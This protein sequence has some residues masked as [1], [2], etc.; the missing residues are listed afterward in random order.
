MKSKKNKI[1][2]LSMAFAL[3]V[4]C[5]SGCGAGSNG[6]SNDYGSEDSSVNI[7]IDKGDPDNPGYIFEADG[8]LTASS[9]SKQDTINRLQATDDYG[10]SSDYID[11]YKKDKDRYVGIFYFTWLGWHGNE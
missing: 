3:A 8:E 6:S 9:V 7:S 5:S 4:L 10:R 2:S 11:G 1:L